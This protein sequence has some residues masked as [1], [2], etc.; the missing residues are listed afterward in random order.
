MWRSCLSLIAMLGPLLALAQSDEVDTRPGPLGPDPEA[1]PTVVVEAP[2]PRYV[3]PTLRDRIG[4]IWAPVL[5]NGRG[6][7]RLVLNTGANSSAILPSVVEKLG[8]SLEGTRK[9][10]ING[11]TGSAVVPVVDAEQLEIGE[12]LIQQVR[13]PI[14]PDVFGGAEGVLGPSGFA[15]KR[16][17]IDFRNDLIRIAR[18]NRERA[19]GGFTRV[20]L[21]ANRRQLLMFDI[22]IG[23]VRTTAVLDTGAQQTM[24]NQSLREALLRKSKR[25]L[26]NQEIVGVTLDVAEGQSINIPPIALGDVEISN[27]QVHFGNDFIFSHWDLTEKPAIV[28]GMDLIGT[29]ETLIIDYRMAELQLRARQRRSGVVEM[30][31]DGGS[32]LDRQEDNRR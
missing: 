17:F 7:F 11:A 23:K 1:T 30:N 4:R 29:L 13:L 18:S 5:I 20:P 14:V 3:A 9:I 32:L 22:K 24:G 31:F 8:I 12:L 26:K 19:A 10:K 21:K 2:E 25:G 15:D 27:L 16:I 28:I 6:P